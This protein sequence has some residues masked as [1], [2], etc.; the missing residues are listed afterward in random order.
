MGACACCYCCSLYAF[1]LAK[2]FVATNVCV[3]RVLARECGLP[4]AF[5]LNARFLCVCLSITTG[6][7]S[8]GIF[9]SLSLDVCIASIVCLLA[10]KLDADTLGYMFC[11]GGFGNGDVSKSFSIQFI[12]IKRFSLRFAHFFAFACLATGCCVL[13]PL[14]YRCVGPGSEHEHPNKKPNRKNQ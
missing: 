8:S 2:S 14:V 5:L 7:S 9:W 4:C 10:A 11:I 13:F 3:R 1:N 12:V 6:D